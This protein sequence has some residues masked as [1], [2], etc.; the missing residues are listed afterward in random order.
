M[1]SRVAAQQPST[2][3][4]QSVA[5]LI[6]ISDA[7]Y[8]SVRKSSCDIQHSIAPYQLPIKAAWRHPELPACMHLGA[9]GDSSSRLS[10]PSTFKS[11]NK[12]RKLAEFVELV[13]LHRPGFMR[14]TAT[15]RGAWVRDGG[16]CATPFPRKETGAGMSCV[17]PWPGLALRRPTASKFLGSLLLHTLSTP[18][19]YCVCC[20]G[21]LHVVGKRGSYDQ[22]D[23]RGEMQPLWRK[24]VRLGRFVAL[25]YW[26]GP[27]HQSHGH[28][29]QQAK[30]VG[31]KAG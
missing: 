29:W 9:L 3:G 21:E 2:P 16:G 6:N 8:V 25:G 23:T 1:P 26:S 18:A 15:R 5:T 7:Q 20:A 24:V 27:S 31:R 17:C 19:D 10:R 12:S 14:V 11:R 22:W 13:S 30:V 4:F 28:H